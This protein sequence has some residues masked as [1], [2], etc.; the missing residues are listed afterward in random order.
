MDIEDLKEDFDELRAELATQRDEI[1]V[2]LHLAG[3][4]AKDAWEDVEKQWHHLEAKSAQI[5]AEAKD[6]G[7]DIAAAGKLLADEIKE[8][9]KRL[10]KLM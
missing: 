4:E 2:R 6:A 7:G 8:G 5:G 3:A 10:L 9:Y 1:R